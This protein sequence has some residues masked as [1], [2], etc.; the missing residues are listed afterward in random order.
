[1]HDG[2]SLYFG[3]YVSDIFYFNTGI[4]WHC[5]DGEITE[6]NDFPEDLYARESHK[7]H[8]EEIYVWSRK[9]IVGCLYQNNQ[10]YSIHIYF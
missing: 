7:N 4:W 1:M 10:L 5:D 9:T 6:I 3:H 8:K 2:D